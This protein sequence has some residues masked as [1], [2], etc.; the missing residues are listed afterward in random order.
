MGGTT[1]WRI[2]ISKDAVGSAHLILSSTHRTKTSKEGGSEK[3]GNS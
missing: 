1:L 2:D 3:R